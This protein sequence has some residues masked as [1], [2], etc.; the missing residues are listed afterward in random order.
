[1]SVVCWLEKAQVA[2]SG[3]LK[4]TRETRRYSSIQWGKRLERV[5][6]Y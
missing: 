6:A 4:P 2:V 5:I 3:S 1:M